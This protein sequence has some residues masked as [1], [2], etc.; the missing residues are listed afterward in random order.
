MRTKGE[1]VNNAFSLIGVSSLTR[2]VRP[3][4]MMRGLHSL[5]NMMSELEE[6]KNLQLG[7]RFTETPDSI[8]DHGVLRQFWDMMSYN[9]AVRLTAI[10]EI[11]LN[12]EV[13]GRARSS[14]QSAY[15]A[16]SKNRVF[17]Y[18]NPRR[19][20]IGSGNSR[21]LPYRRFYRDGTP[22]SSSD[23][24]IRR[25]DVADFYEDY[26]AYLEP[27]ETIDAYEI[28]ADIGLTVVSDSNDSPRINYRLRGESGT[29]N[30]QSRKVE[31]KITT[32]AGRVETRYPQ[33]FLLAEIQIQEG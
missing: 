30:S 16:T 4:D 17:E 12:T 24:F 23:K 1:I 22:P 8:T 15:N 26:T 20:P 18:S 11:P 21:R 32:S 31:V 2:A 27:G 14:L 19:M 7:Y 29:D 13:A 33:F 10:Y 28:K 25:G 6:A 5:D 3:D 9:L